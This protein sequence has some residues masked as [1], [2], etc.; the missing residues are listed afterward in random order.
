MLDQLTPLGVQ[1][2]QVRAGGISL[3][4]CANTRELPAYTVVMRGR[5]EIYRTHSG[6]PAG[7]CDR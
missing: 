5:G 3:R 7:A 4:Q 6:N 1:Q 2:V